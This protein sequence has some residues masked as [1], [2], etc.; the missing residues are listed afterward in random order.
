VSRHITQEVCPWNGPKLVQATSESDYLP[1]VPR[2][3]GS[4][5]DPES[6]TG[7][8]PHTHT[9]GGP[10]TETPSLVALMRMSYEEWDVWTRG[11]AIRRAGYAGFKRNVAVGL[12]NWLA[13][14]DEPPEEAVAVLREAV[15]NG[16]PL[17]REHA[18][19]AL[20]RSVG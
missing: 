10:A 16:E 12:G 2:L 13:G 19:W 5:P 3:S 4:R 17:V 15:E 9:H 7:T 6:G 11:S 1:R 20:E 8:H 18:A 14:L